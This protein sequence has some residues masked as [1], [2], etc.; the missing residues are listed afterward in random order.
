ME[1]G[2][3]APTK[4]YV[5]ELQ[6]DIECTSGITIAEIG[7]TSLDRS[8]L[9]KLRVQKEEEL[10]EYFDGRTEDDED[11]SGD[12]WCYCNTDYSSRPAWVISEYPLL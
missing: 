2:T 4:V 10:D 7:G 11:D 5:L 1:N 3:N 6:G 9:E 8:T 12:S